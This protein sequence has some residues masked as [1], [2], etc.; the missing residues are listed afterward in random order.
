MDLKKVKVYLELPFM[1]DEMTF[2]AEFHVTEGARVFWNPENRYHQP[3]FKLI[4]HSPYLLYFRVQLGYVDLSTDCCTEPSSRD[5]IEDYK[6]RR[7]AVD[8]I[9]FVAL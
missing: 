4:P 8:K 9:E 5:G 1:N 3:L 2:A 7:N 6:R